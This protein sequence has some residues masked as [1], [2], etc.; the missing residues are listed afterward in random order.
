MVCPSQRTRR[1]KRNTNL[2]KGDS[3]NRRRTYARYK[4]TLNKE[5]RELKEKRR[6]ARHTAHMTAK[7]QLYTSHKMTMRD[8]RGPMIQADGSK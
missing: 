2:K 8:H 7:A 5:A 3:S 6:L 4:P 1:T